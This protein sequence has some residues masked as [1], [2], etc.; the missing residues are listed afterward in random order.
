MGTKGF[1]SASGS[2]VGHQRV[3]GE[4]K[5]KKKQRSAGIPG[6]TNKGPGRLEDNWKQQHEAERDGKV[7]GERRRR[8]EQKK[9]RRQVR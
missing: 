5:Q 4:I 7:E 8:G 9:R 2:S 1:S 3:V 6:Q